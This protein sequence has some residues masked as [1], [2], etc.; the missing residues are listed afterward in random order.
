MKRIAKA[1]AAVALAVGIGGALAAPA[2]AA[3][4]GWGGD[5]PNVNQAGLL[6]L[7]CTPLQVPI[8]IGGIALPIL[9]VAADAG[10]QRTNTQAFACNDVDTYRNGKLDGAR[11]GWVHR[12]DWGRKPTTTVVIVK[13]GDDGRPCHDG[14]HDGCRPCHDDPCRD[15]N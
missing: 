13:C 12:G 2:Q 4:T 3:V 1:A 9:G 15:G 5:N 14:C 7:N 6:N 10:N 8:S 11:P